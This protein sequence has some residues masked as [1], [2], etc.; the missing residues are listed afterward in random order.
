MQCQQ[1]NSITLRS[2]SGSP[3]RMTGALRAQ[4]SAH[5]V[6]SPFPT[7]SLLSSFIS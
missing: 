7:V 6:T 1:H 5:P 2:I 3:E 4:A